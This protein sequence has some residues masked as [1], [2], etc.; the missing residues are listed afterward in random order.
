M[1]WTD[2]D[3]FAVVTGRGVETWTTDPADWRAHVCELAGRSLDDDEWAQFGTDAAPRAVESWLAESQLH[4][5]TLV[6]LSTST[7]AAYAARW[8][9]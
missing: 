4:T 9:S 2:P 7:C 5:N 1:Q 3:S 6:H 8:K